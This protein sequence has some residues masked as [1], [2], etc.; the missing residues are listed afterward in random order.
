LVGCIRIRPEPHS[1]LRI[2]KEG[3]TLWL[4]KQP[5]ETQMPPLIESISLFPAPNAPD[6]G[7]FVRRKHEFKTDPDV[8]FQ[9]VHVDRL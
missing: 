1:W 4:N 9:N 8:D 5:K 6:L 7:C 3:R 2:R